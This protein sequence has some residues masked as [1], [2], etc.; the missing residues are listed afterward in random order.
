[1]IFDFRFFASTESNRR[2]KY[3]MDYQQGQGDALLGV[4]AIAEEFFGC[5]GSR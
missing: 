2:Q 1:M 3:A 5:R 4:E